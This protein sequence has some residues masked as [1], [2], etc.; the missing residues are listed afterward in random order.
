MGTPEGL[1]YVLFTSG[2]TGRPKGVAIEQ[3]SVLNRILWMQSAFPIGPGDVI[4]QKTPVTFDVS[5]WELFWWAWTGAAVALP[6]PGAER[7][8]LALADLIERDGVTVLHFVPSM[9]AAFL[10]ALEDGRV[11][12]ARLRRLRYVF[13]S[14]EALDSGP[15]ATIRPSASPALRDAVAQPLRPYRSYR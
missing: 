14:G 6:P 9:L 11:D 5:V 7:D 15:G 2:S 4:L 8:P 1:A 10:A 3:H 13:S 12:A